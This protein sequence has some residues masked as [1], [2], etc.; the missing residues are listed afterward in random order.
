MYT[1]LKIY[2]KKKRISNF[3][4]YAVVYIMS[5][6]SYRTGKLHCKCKQTNTPFFSTCNVDVV[7]KIALNMNKGKIFF[8]CNTIK[9]L[10]L[11]SYEHF[12][13]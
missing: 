9:L 13:I 1:L 5:C 12:K 11:P 6:I 8:S 3:V 10:W 7:C 2:G 4:V